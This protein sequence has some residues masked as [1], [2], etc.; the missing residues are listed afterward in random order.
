MAIDLS[1]ETVTK[2]F[3]DFTAVRD[4]SFA[5]EQGRFFSI[6]GPSGCGKTTLLR[7][8]AGFIAPSGGRILIRGS[9]MAGYPPNR[10]PGQPDLST[11]RPFPHD[12][13]CPE[14]Q[15]SASSVARKKNRTLIG[16]WRKSWSGWG[17]PV[18]GKKRIDQ[19]S[20]GQKQRVAIARCLVLE[21]AVL[22]LDEPLGALDL[23]L[24]E[25]R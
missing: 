11:P 7:M 19:L 5:V 8:I 14:R 18:S 9:D 16:K 12:E 20:G 25:T 6:L 23:K 4:V 13:H 3:G 1:V 2:K 24:R 10:R 22:L 15:P 21:P 17:C